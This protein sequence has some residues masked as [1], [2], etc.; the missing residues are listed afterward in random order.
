MEILALI[1]KEKKMWEIEVPIMSLYTCG[2]TKTEA[3]E[4]L[5]DLLESALKDHFSKKYNNK[6]VAIK[7]VVR[8]IGMLGIEAKDMRPLLSYALYRQREESHMTIKQVAKR[9]GSKYPNAY[10]KYERGNINITL[11]QYNKLIHA[12]SPN[13][14]LILSL[15]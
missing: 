7:I 6:K 14:E 1:K 11:N 15:A 12:I 2:R 5:K 3:I 10:A 9:L 13:R 4:M 8:E